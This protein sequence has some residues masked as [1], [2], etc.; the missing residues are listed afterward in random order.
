MTTCFSTSGEW[1]E[2]AAGWEDDRALAVAACRWAMTAFAE[3]ITRI[4]VDG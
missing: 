4:E 2:T 3:G 1:D